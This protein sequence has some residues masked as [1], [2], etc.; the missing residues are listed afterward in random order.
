VGAGR[1]PSEIGGALEEEI[2]QR[3]HEFGA[4]TKRPRRCAWFD[5]VVVRHSVA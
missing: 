1:C 4:N 5:A 2:R 3:G